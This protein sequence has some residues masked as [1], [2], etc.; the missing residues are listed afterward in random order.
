MMPRTLSISVALALFSSTIFADSNAKYSELLEQHNLVQ[1][2]QENLKS[3]QSNV[4]VEKSG[5]YPEFRVGLEAGRDNYERDNSPNSHLDTHQV[6]ASINQ[7]LWDFG[8]VNSSINH[9]ESKV[10][11]AE[12]ELDRQKQYLILAG[13]EA[14]LNLYK[15]L[16]I[17]EFAHK[18]EDNIKQQ[19]KLESTRID[20]GQGYTTDLLQAK[21]QLAAA[22]ARR[23]FAEGGLAQ[24]K[25]RYAAV[26]GHETAVQMATDSLPKLNITVPNELKSALEKAM[27]NNPD[28][29]V[30]QADLAIL[31]AEVIKTSKAE[32]MPKIQLRAEHI[33][34]HNPDGIEQER[35][36]NNIVV[37]MDWRFNTGLRANHAEDSVKAK[38]RAATQQ[39]KNKR[40]QTIEDT[41]NAWTQLLTSQTRLSY[42]TNQVE[43][44]E[45]FLELARKERELG[46]R[47][48][49]DVLNGET[50]LI[51]AQSDVAAAQTDLKIS[52]LQLMLQ[53]GQLTLDVFK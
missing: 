28:I 24:A 29:Q 30:S 34:S 1:S 32:W 31:N 17:L 47:S 40:I 22:Q 44:S 27:A 42:L 53:M 45:R 26:F 43:L 16:K 13:L 14:E 46:K 38:A 37:R 41:R 48:L 23:V 36:Q 52:Q 18:S 35:L 50:Q 10:N 20:A 12:S 19:T 6:S 21:T 51:N 5:W 3:A 39:V 33:N 7:L 9:A 4:D 25:N 2:A 11:R 8:A 15:A 49:L